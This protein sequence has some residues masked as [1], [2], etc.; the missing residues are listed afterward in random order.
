MTEAISRE[1]RFLETARLR[2][3]APPRHGHLDRALRGLSGF[4][5]GA[6]LREETARRPSILHRI[7]PRARVAATLLFLVSVSLAHSLPA[8]AAHALLPAAAILL[9][10]I[11][12]GEFLRGGFLPALLFSVLLAA[13]ATLNLF[14]DGEVVWPLLRWDAS[15]RAG[16]PAMPAVVGLTREG[17][18]SAATFLLRVLPSVA[19][20][21]WLALSTPWTELLRALRFFRVPA[22]FVQVTGMTVRYM[23]ALLRQSEEMH[24]GKKSRTICR[25]SAGGERRWAGSRIAAS[26]ERSLHLAEEVAAAMAARGFTG[27]ARHAGGGRL[28]PA[29]WVFLSLVVVCCLLAHAAG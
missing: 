26:W 25:P 18:L 17:L 12:P 15:W 24:F 23:H 14:R 11:R 20:S 7:D 3:L 10:R 6:L 21:L 8:L 28:A 22:A 4:F 27:E 1:R 5:A 2:G 9:S 13:P 29:E 19:A 16:S